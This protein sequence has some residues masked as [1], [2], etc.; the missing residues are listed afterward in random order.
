LVEKK[1]LP[2]ASGDCYQLLAFSKE[3]AESI[4]FGNAIEE[5]NTPYICETKPA[6]ALP[7]ATLHNLKV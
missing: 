1:G 2:Q 5:R 6:S 3:I 7:G 4:V